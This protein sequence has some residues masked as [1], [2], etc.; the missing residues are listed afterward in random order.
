ML[1]KTESNEIRRTGS[2][3]NEWS[4]LSRSRGNLLKFWRSYAEETSEEIDLK[5]VEPSRWLPKFG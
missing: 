5:K 1:T 4:S 3:I 2:L